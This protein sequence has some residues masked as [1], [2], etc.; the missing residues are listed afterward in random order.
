MTLGPDSEK[1]RK[2]LEWVVAERGLKPHLGVRV[3]FESCCLNFDLKL[4]E[5]EALY[6]LMFTQCDDETE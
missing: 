6:K 2:A 4:A 1:V 3:I 5:C